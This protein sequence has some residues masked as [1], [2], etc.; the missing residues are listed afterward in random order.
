M[1]DEEIAGV[2]DY[3]TQAIDIVPEI[4]RPAAHVDP[5]PQSSESRALVASPAASAPAA[6]VDSRSASSESRA[7]MS[8]TVGHDRTLSDSV[9]R[10]IATELPR[11]FTAQNLADLVQQDKR[12]AQRTIATWLDEGIIDQVQLGRY[13]L[14]RG[15]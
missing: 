7:P 14:K 12:T 6:H 4:D 1:G 2:L 13:A 8:D 10:R 11:I 5:R 9:A 3:V 15:T